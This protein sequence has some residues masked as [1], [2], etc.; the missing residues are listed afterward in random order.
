MRVLIDHSC[1]EVYL[2]NKI[3]FTT[4]IYPKF[5]NSDYLHFFD[6]DGGM[7]VS[8]VSI[9]RFGSVYFDETTPSYYGNTGNLGEE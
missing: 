4:R 7:K 9:K 1:L 8:D 3:T 5:G 2:N 6:N